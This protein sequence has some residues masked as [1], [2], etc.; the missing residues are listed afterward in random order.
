MGTWLIIVIVIAVVIAL[1]LFMLQRVIRGAGKDVIVRTVIDI[2]ASGNYH[3]ELIPANEVHSVDLVQLAISYIANIILLSTQG[4]LKISQL[5]DELIQFSIQ[6][7]ELSDERL[8]RQELNNLARTPPDSLLPSGKLAV[9]T[10]ERYQVRLIRG[11]HFDYSLSEFSIVGYKPN[12]E[13]SAALLYVEIASMLDDSYLLLLH[14]SLI[15][16]I[17]AFQRQ[18]PTRNNNQAGAFVVVSYMLSTFPGGI[19]HI[20][21]PRRSPPASLMG[22]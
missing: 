19:E 6:H 1:A 10:S 18:K 12:L 15:G 8:L 2:Y 9:G 3:V 20:A 16:L 7:E 14:K 17:D 4:S 13:N 21:D 5:L 22:R 11:K